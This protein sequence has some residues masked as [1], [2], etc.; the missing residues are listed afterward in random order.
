MPLT[1]FHP[2]AERRRL[3]AHA[4]F[5]TGILV[6]ILVP[7]ALFGTQIDSAVAAYFSGDHPG[8][9]ASLIIF[10]L[11]AVDV[12]LPIPSSLVAT[13]AGSVS[14]PVIGAITVCLGLTCSNFLGWW[15]GRH[16]GRPVFAKLMGA[17]RK[18]T[19]GSQGNIVTLAG[20]VMTRAVPVLAESLVIAAGMQNMRLLPFLMAVVPANLGVGLVYAWF[21]SIAADTGSFLLVFVA[22]IV[23]PALVWLGY[24]LVAGRFPLP[25]RREG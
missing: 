21:G 7:F 14:G 1:R 9:V 10:L 24:R 3:I 25:S 6:L 12:V 15:L 20:L 5:W 22:S 4:I 19:T 8:L 13:L 17:G 18:N 11:L 16:A 23:L 2:L